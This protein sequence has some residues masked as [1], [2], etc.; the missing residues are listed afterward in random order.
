[1]NKIIIDRGVILKLPDEIVVKQETV[2]V[3]ARLKKL[4][5]EFNLKY[6]TENNAL[7][8]KDSI[9]PFIY[10]DR[11]TET[12]TGKQLLIKDIKDLEHALVAGDTFRLNSEKILTLDNYKIFKS[13]INKNCSGGIFINDF[14]IYLQSE[15]MLTVNMEA[16][17]VL[18]DHFGVSNHITLVD[19]VANNTPDFM[20][21]LHNIY[22]IH[23]GAFLNKVNKLYKEIYTLV[24]N[25][26]SIDYLFNSVRFKLVGNNLTIIEGLPPSTIRYNLNIEMRKELEK[27]SN[28]DSE[29]LNN[30]I[31]IGRDG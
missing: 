15:I 29:I 24:V 27:D 31:G 4:N 9:E 28:E 3:P 12:T 13:G 1:M 14:L 5:E 17:I 8:F 25:R 21:Y 6:I 30:V 26:L 23:D 10:T 19:P 16:H 22:E 7:Y 18:A 11:V 2:V 20:S